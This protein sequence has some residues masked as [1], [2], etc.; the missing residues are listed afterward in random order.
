MQDDFY[1]R[2][3]EL[4]T[5]NK[6][7]RFSIV[8]GERGSDSVNAGYYIANKMGINYIKLPDVKVDTVRKM[9]SDAYKIHSPLVYI[10]PNA[11]DMSV[12]AKNAL[13]KVT[14]EPPNKAYIVMCLEDINNTL[15]TI[16]SRGTVFQMDRY[17]PD[18]LKE[19]ARELYVNKS[20]IDEKD[21]DVI[22]DVC[23]TP[24]EVDMLMKSGV[25]EFYRYVE[26]ASLA[27]Q[28]M[29]GSEVFNYL[30]KLAYKDEEDK[31]DCIL[32]LKAFQNLTVRHMCEHKDLG[33]C[34]KNCS[35]EVVRGTSIYLRDLKIKGINKQMLMEDWAL[36]VRKIWKSAN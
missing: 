30:K 4:I 34:G 18:E 20:D 25:K 3:E 5:N 24:G 26:Y 36:E 6:F 32:F 21:I 22:A 8:V 28:D 23:S 13:L 15:A 29:K 9:I 14:E 1:S 7:P 2:L 11:D 17:T 35:C 33:E 27:L 10:I 31:F 12:N 19:Y 16:K